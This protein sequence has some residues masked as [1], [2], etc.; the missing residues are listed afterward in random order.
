[1]GRLN[2]SEWARAD[3]PPAVSSS[4]G[5]MLTGGKMAT[6]AIE[7]KFGL[8]MEGKGP[9]TYA[10][11]IDQ[12]NDETLTREMLIPKNDGKAKEKILKLIAENL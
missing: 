2:P 1:M 10:K 7:L 6:R 11:V 4:E 5:F 12:A 3:Y 9:C 8:E